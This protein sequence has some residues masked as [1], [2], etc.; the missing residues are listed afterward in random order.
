M[1][2]CRDCNPFFLMGVRKCPAY[3]C[4]CVQLVLSDYLNEIKENTVNELKNGQTVAEGIR[5]GDKS[6]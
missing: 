4:E 2:G 6:V 1:N 5:E 3:L